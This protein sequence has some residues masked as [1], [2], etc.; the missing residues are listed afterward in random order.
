MNTIIQILIFIGVFI[1]LSFKAHAQR[2]GDSAIYACSQRWC[3][4]VCIQE[5]QHFCVTA[6]ISVS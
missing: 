4:S 3:S 2:K 1:H 6:Y 5:L